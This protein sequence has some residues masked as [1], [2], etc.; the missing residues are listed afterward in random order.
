MYMLLGNYT[1]DDSSEI[2]IQQHTDR[3]FN[4]FDR[5]HDD[6]ITMDNFFEIC[7]NVSLTLVA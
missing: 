7:T 6:V 5:D 4:K 2:A 1:E 3:V